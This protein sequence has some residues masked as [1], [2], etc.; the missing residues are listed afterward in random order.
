MEF[1]RYILRP[2]LWSH[3]PIATRLII[4]VTYMI[5]YPSL[6][7]FKFILVCMNLFPFTKKLEI[8]RVGL[9]ILLNKMGRILT[10]LFGFA[11]MW[12]VDHRRSVNNVLLYFFYFVDTKLR[13]VYNTDR[14]MNEFKFL[15]LHV[16][17]N[18]FYLQSF[19]IGVTI[20]FTTGVL[21]FKSS[22]RTGSIVV[23]SGYYLILISVLSAVN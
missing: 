8:R 20:F 10:L 2:H 23:K 13:T 12:R 15:L 18:Q 16:I 4:P 6:N 5:L 19:V 14:E 11:K 17:E 22:E 1:Y 21:S 9:D 7:F 3:S